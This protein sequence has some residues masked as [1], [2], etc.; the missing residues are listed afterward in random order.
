MQ[1]MRNQNVVVLWHYTIIIVTPEL[2][3]DFSYRKTF[4]R[5]KRTNGSGIIYNVITDLHKFAGVIFGITQKL[6]YIT[7]SKF[8]R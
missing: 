2:K 8:F 6:L 3:T 5:F 4:S 7:S 1:N